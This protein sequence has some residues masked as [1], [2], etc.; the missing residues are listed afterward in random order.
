[1]GTYYQFCPVSKAL[2]VLDE[3]WTL[4]I[5]RELLMGSR[6][7]ND[8]RR[9]VPRMSPALLVKRLQ[10]LERVG[11]VERFP[12]GNK[13]IYRLTPAGKDL[14]QIV[15]G[16]GDWSLRWLPELGDEDLDP[17]LLFWD[18]RRQV[19]REDLPPGRTVVHV[20]LG[21]VDPKSQRWWLVL[22]ADD[23]DVCDFDPGLPVAVTLETTLRCMT[24]LWRGEISWREAVR[25]GDLIANGSRTATRAVPR[26]L[27]VRAAPGD[28]RPQFSVSGRLAVDLRA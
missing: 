5:V 13:V 9:G 24:H 22:A 28:P 26:W 7:F 11:V 6:H 3:R 14:Q 1:M 27:N 21:D 23:A 8:I 16:L 19:S 25:A 15:D 10:R 18:M 12:D 17:H 20:Q 2:E 4:L